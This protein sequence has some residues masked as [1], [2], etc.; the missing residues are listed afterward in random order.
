MSEYTLEMRIKDVKLADASGWTHI[1]FSDKV[2]GDPLIWGH[3]G[4]PPDRLSASPFPKTTVPLFH[5]DREATA[6]LLQ[7]LA[8][9]DERWADFF[10]EMVN[11]LDPNQR[12][13]NRVWLGKLLMLAAPAQVATAALKSLGLEAE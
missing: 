12:W 2:S 4:R 8:T 13:G 3:L 9:D 1:S 7:W 5:R 6:D 11:I 10:D